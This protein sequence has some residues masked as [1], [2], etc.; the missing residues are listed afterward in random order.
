MRA[1]ATV[2]RL[3]VL[4]R[5]IVAGTLCAGVLGCVAGLALG[6]LVYPPTAWFAIFELGIPAVDG[7]IT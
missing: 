7:L 2:M 3:P 4:A 5:F 1:S 6:L